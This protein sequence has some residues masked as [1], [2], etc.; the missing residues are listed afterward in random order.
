MN[1]EQAI[2]HLFFHI[3]M[4]DG[5]FD[6]PEVDFIAAKVVS[7]GLRP[8]IDFKKEVSEYLQS[9]ND[10]ND[11]Q[12]YLE[13]IISSIK[14]VNMLALFSWCVEICLMDELITVAEEQLLIQ[15]A[16]VLAISEEQHTTIVDL[17]VERKAAD[18]NHTV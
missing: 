9:R 11:N 7:L 1:S 10:W 17:M 13:Y 6:E 15:L 5:K 3:A 4:Q 12:A 14:P 2:C 8:D 18:L 16:E